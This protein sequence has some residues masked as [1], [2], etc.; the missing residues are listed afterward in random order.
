VPASAGLPAGVSTLFAGIKAPTVTVP[1]A[2]I[3]TDC[4]L[5]TSIC[6]LNHATSAGNLND[7]KLWSPFGGTVCCAVFAGLS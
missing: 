7:E 6:V 1:L 2:V 3:V 4:P 5:V